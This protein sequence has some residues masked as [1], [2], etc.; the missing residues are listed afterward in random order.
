[1][2]NR[3]RAD[4]DLG[5]ADT[6]V[7]DAQRHVATVAATRKA[8]ASADGGD[9]AETAGGDSDLVV[10]HILGNDY[11]I[12]C[13]NH[14]VAQAVE[15]AHDRFLLDLAAGHRM[16]GE[17]SG[18]YGAIVDRTGIEAVGGGRQLDAAQLWIRTDG[19]THIILFV[20][21]EIQR[22]G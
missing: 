19:N 10:G 11:A 20:K 8:R 9:I 4:R 18:S 3:H 12:T 14:V 7:G 16:V 2:R 21:V 15:R 13:E 22:I 6:A 5:G 17:L 1:M